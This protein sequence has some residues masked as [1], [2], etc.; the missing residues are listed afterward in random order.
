MKHTSLL[1]RA[2]AASVTLGTAIAGAVVVTSGPAQA[3]L[4]ETNFGFY[5]YAFGTSVKGEHEGLRS[6][7]T[8][9]AFL[10][11]TRLAGKH[12]DQ[13]VATGDAPANNPAF[14]I[15]AVTSSSDTFKRANGDVGSTSNSK[16]ANVRIGPADGPHLVI[17]GL[18][19][20]ASAWADKFGK[21]HTDGTFSLADILA[22]TGTPLDDVLNNALSPLQALV[23][24]VLAAPGDHLDIPGLGRVSLGRK[25]S[26]IYLPYA[27]ANTLG[28]RVLLFGPNGVAGGGDDS[29]L[30]IGRTHA[31]VYRNL[32]GGVMGGY[33][34]AADAKVLSG[35]VSV[36]QLAKRPLDCNGTN[37]QIET[38]TVSGLNLLN[39]GALDLGKAS[40]RVYGVQQ[41]DRSVVAWTEGRLSDLSLGTGSNK[42]VIKGVIAHAEMRKAKNGNI[43]KST[44][45]TT[46]ES[47]SYDGKEYDA[48]EPGDKIEIPGL[49]TIQFAIVD[50]SSKNA[51]TV[52]ALRITLVPAAA[53]DTG[54]ATINLGVATVHVR[55]L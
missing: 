15:G 36:G 13:A 40:G 29:S 4:Q 55:R 24:Q 33:G 12:D 9:F 32:P 19:T 41:K 31:R 5:T 3:A 46:F 25:T 37:G 54:L 22:A 2:A 27:M 35:L 11:C 21:F 16:L 17:K 48:P 6:A 26:S 1:V 53:A 42:L 23:R 45:G 49:A 34:Y 10:G 51:L 39:L 38:N 20:S 47:M 14:G 18:Q 52:T 8:A 30:M 43:T 28:L 44:A 7:P 50:N